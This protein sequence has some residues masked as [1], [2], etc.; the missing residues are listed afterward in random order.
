[1]AG[2]RAA[3]L[4]EIADA[5]PEMMRLLARS[6]PISSGDWELTIVQ[7]RALGLIGEHPDCT[8]GELARRLGIGLSATTALADRLLQQG[9]IEREAD[10]ADRRLV[11]LRLA[12]AGRRAREGV[13]RE[14]RR[15]VAAAMGQLTTGELEQVANAFALLRKALGTAE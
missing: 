2:D 8:M 11:C 5:L 9:L 7:M 13:R 6:R 15:R 14:R 3:L 12:R 1:M 10:P 4:V